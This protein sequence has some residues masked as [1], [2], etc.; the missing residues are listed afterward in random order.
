RTKNPLIA[1]WYNSNLMRLFLKVFSRRISEKW[2]RFLEEDYL[3]IP[4][5]TETTKKTDL[6]NI[7]KTIENYLCKDEKC[8]NIL[9][10]LTKTFGES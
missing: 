2:T 9:R 8:R 6:K 1:A 10:D 3:V 5:P 4:I 7:D